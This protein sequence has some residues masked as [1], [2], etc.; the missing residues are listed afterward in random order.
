MPVQLKVIPKYGFEESR[1]GVCQSVS[2]FTAFNHDADEIVRANFMNYL[3]NP[4]YQRLVDDPNMNI[5]GKWTLCLHSGVYATAYFHHTVGSRHFVGVQELVEGIS[6]IS[7][8]TVLRSFL[9]WR[10]LDVR[11]LALVTDGWIQ[12]GYACKDNG[13]F[14]AIFRAWRD[15]PCQEE[16]Q[17]APSSEKTESVLLEHM[18]PECPLIYGGLMDNL[19]APSVFLRSAKNDWAA[20]MMTFLR[21]DPEGP[22]A[23]LVDP[24]PPR[25]GHRDEIQGRWATWR[26]ELGGEGERLLKADWHSVHNWG[27]EANAFVPRAASICGLRRAP[28]RLLAFLECFRDVNHKC[29][30]AVLTRLERLKREVDPKDPDAADIPWLVKI[31]STAMR[32]RGHFGAMEA[33]VWWGQHDMTTRSHKDGATSLLHL[34]LTLSGRR[35]VR[36]GAFDTALAPMV[37]DPCTNQRAQENVWCENLWYQGRLETIELH[38]GMVYCS[39]PFVFEHGVSY[40]RCKQEDPM[41]AVQCRFAFPDL[42]DAEH[43]NTMR[44]AAMRKVTTVIAETIREAGDRGELRMPTLQEVQAAERVIALS[45][46]KIASGK[47]EDRLFMEFPPPDDISI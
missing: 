19:R 43:I 24:W 10:V 9:Q 8:T 23:G 17:E 6:E 26:F 18:D 16:V 3:I 32:K 28:R 34:S 29:W 47:R 22:F 2:A 12:N 38:P 13:E 44:N 46:A 7:D 20:D 1:R 21:E 11:F 4:G 15:E 31:L 37:R 5:S 14:V 40:E 25:R 30:T 41:I 45:E 27:T 39:A 33:Q 42:A 36:V 35:S